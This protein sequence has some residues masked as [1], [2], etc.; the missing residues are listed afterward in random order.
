MNSNIEEERTDF[1]EDEVIAWEIEE[2]EL[3][4]DYPQKKRVNPDGWK[5]N[6]EKNKRIKGLESVTSQG[7]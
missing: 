4:L 7:L 5:K 1:I 3:F 6:I 2:L